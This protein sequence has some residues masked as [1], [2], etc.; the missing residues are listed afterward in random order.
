MED[1]DNQSESNYID[2]GG[3][4]WQRREEAREK[5][6]CRDGMTRRNRLQQLLREIWMLAE[7][8]GTNRRWKDKNQGQ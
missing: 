3:E 4:I 8:K 6:Q 1:E 5:E 2:V 7:A